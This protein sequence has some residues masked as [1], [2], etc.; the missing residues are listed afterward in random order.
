M[1]KLLKHDRREAIYIGISVYCL[2]IDTNHNML[3]EYNL[4]FCVVA[5]KLW[6]E[7]KNYCWLLLIDCI[8]VWTEQISKQC[9][10]LYRYLHI[11]NI[12]PTNHNTLYSPQLRYL[13]RKNA[14]KIYS[15]YTNDNSSLYKVDACFYIAQAKIC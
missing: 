8:K 14:H 10:H 3:K 6:L 1:E 5:D 2:I 4:S 12:T 9:L 15:S 11:N 7:V 13:Y